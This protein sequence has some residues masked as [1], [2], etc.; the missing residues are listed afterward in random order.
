[1][2]ALYNS[3]GDRAS[4]LAELREVRDYLLKDV[5]VDAEILALLESTIF[6]LESMSDAD[7]A[8]LDVFP[9]F[10]PEETDGG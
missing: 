9:D 1:M 6:K 7:Y 5:P 2:I 4:A 8:A 10:L 3:G